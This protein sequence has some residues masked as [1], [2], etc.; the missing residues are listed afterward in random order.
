[1]SADHVC[2]LCHYEFS[3]GATVCQGCFGTIVYGATDSEVDESAKAM[4]LLCGFGAAFVLFALPVILNSKFGTSL[5]AGWNLGW[6]S[7]V[8]LLA[9]AIWGYHRGVV[10]AERKH[11]GKVRTFRRM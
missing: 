7:L 4:A 6:W 3:D 1:M 10:N 8:P 5:S 2:G 9:A 11:R